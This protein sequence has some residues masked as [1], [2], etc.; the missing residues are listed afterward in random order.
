MVIARD[1]IF[2]EIVTKLYQPNCILHGGKIYSNISNMPPHEYWMS[3][4]YCNVL[5]WQYHFAVFKHFTN[6]FKKIDFFSQNYGTASKI[7]VRIIR[8]PA[9]VPLN[10]LCLKIYFHIVLEIWISRTFSML[11]K[12][13]IHGK[14]LACKRFFI[15]FI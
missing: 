13:R 4:N 14:F 5:E 15:N 12:R 8:V 6:L 11:F 3:Q 2:C 9:T 1:L 10:W 7:H